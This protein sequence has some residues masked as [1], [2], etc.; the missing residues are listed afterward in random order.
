MEIACIDPHQTGFVG[1]GSDHLQLIKFWR[2]RAP[3]K[4]VCGVAKIFGSALVT[5]SQRA[6][7]ASPLS[8][9][10]IDT[11]VLFRSGSFQSVVLVQSTSVRNCTASFLNT[12]APRCSAIFEAIPCQNRYAAVT[13]Y[14]TTRLRRDCGWTVAR[15]TFDAQQV[16]LSRA[17]TWSSEI[18]R[19][20]R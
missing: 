5:N 15:L 1:K 8:A 6:V 17:S 12:A 20:P 4:G 18:V 14:N 10:F 3:E 19:S 11:S 16:A 2:S 7:F 13:T 9:I